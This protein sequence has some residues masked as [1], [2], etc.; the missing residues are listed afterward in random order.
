MAYGSDLTGV[1]YG[2]GLYAAS[3]YSCHK[4]CTFFQPAKMS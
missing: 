4:L 3:Q 1:I 2:I